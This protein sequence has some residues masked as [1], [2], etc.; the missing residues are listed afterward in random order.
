M[1]QMGWE[2][3]G[4][5]ENDR[6]KKLES[7]TEEIGNKKQWRRKLAQMKEFMEK[8][9]KRACLGKEKAGGGWQDIERRG[10]KIGKV[11]ENIISELERVSQIGNV[12]LKKFYS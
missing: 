2:K 5:R 10:Y 3:K 11:W 1:I 7:S 8:R 4:E 12:K 6:I 9:I